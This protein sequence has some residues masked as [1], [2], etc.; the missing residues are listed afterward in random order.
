MVYQLPQRL[1]GRGIAKGKVL[2]HNAVIATGKHF[3]N[4]W[5]SIA[6]CPACFLHVVL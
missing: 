1:G 3:T 2:Q 4:G 5:F 6:A